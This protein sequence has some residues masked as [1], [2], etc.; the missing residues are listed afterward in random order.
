[1]VVPPAVPEG[2]QTVFP[3][4]RMSCSVVHGARS[5]CGQLVRAP[6]A[7]GSRLCAHTN[8]ASHSIF[9]INEQWITPFP[10]TYRPSLVDLVESGSHLRKHEN[11]VLLPHVLCGPIS[12]LPQETLPNNSPLNCHSSHY[13]L[14]KLNC[15]AIQVGNPFLSI[16]LFLVDV[17]VCPVI[18]ILMQV[19]Y[20]LGASPPFTVSL[21]LTKGTHR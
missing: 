6:P 18:T 10:K 3:Q 11:V 7:L 14:R 5:G 17:M 21:P 4:R 8:S 15:G 2:D 13:D 16:Q 19:H 12:H 20:R 1:M 9:K